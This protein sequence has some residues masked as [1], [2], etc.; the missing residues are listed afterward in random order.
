MYRGNVTPS[1]LM[2]GTGLE[3]NG[4]SLGYLLYVIGGIDQ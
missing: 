3:G 2:G 1:R 4:G